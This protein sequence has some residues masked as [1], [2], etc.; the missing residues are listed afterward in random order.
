MLTL[1]G[2]FILWGL[3]VTAPLWP[4]H[5]II[6][7]TMQTWPTITCYL[8]ELMIAPHTFNILCLA[9]IAPIMHYSGNYESPYLSL[10]PFHQKTRSYVSITTS[11]WTEL[12]GLTWGIISRLFVCFLISESVSIAQAPSSTYPLLLPWFRLQFLSENSQWIILPGCATLLSLSTLVV[13][14]YRAAN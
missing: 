11:S 2:S 1:S 3:K 8:T 5:W 12:F 7:Y 14:Y 4:V 13:L 10:H 9:L 6:S